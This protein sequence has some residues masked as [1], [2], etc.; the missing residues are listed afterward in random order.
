L[1]KTR[2]IINSINPH[3]DEWN[4]IWNEYPD[5]R[6]FMR[7]RGRNYRLQG[8]VKENKY[9][10]K[11]NF[12]FLEPFFNEL[13]NLRNKFTE[14]PKLNIQLKMIEDSNNKKNIYLRIQPQKIYDSTFNVNIANYLFKSLQK[15]DD[16]KIK[17][18]WM[19]L[20]ANANFIICR[21]EQ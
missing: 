2:E 14:E 4:K 10:L 17:P 19:N 1:D 5:L 7:V 6:D 13:V 21:F 18:A 11:P 16:C 20:I 15:I 3:S 8:K 9:K 12:I